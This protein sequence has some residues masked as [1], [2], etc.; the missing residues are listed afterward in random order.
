MYGSHAARKSMLMEAS[1]R[2]TS[3][4]VARGSSPTP[5]S[6]APIMPMTQIERAVGRGDPDALR[7][8]RNKAQTG[9]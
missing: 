7:I 4:N 5:A 2:W 3:A 1:S 8:Y 6:T 9:S